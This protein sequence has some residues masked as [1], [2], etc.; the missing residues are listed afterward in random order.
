MG[1]PS[2][3]LDPGKL[4]SLRSEKNAGVKNHV[5]MYVL[6]RSQWFEEYRSRLDE[7]RE[8]GGPPPAYPSERVDTVERLVDSLIRASLDPG[9]VR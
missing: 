7:Y 2:I 5:M 1:L 9:H 8:R 6:L 4:K 3:L